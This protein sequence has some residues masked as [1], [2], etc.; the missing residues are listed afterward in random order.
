MIKNDRKVC[1]IE[2]NVMIFSGGEGMEHKKTYNAKELKTPHGDII[3]EG[4]I[5][6]DKLAGY[7]FHEHLTAFR[8][9][10]TTTRSP[11]WDCTTRRGANYYRET[12]P[13]H[14]RLCYIPVSR[15]S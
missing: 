2:V 1:I 4:P 5:S 15:S 14:R 8:P 7:E 3:I 9:P 13:Y 12:S 6:S 11:N 10:R